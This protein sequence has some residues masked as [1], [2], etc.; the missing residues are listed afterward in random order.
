M[1]ESSEKN[2]EGQSADKVVD[3]SSA[4]EVGRRRRRK[5]IIAAVSVVCVIAL[6]VV[7]FWGS[8]SSRG[9]KDLF[10]PTYQ[11]GAD[12]DFAFETG[13][14]QVFA[15]VGDCLAVAS[16]GGLQI[17]DEDGTTIG[18]LV[19]SMSTPAI[20][21]S[22]SYCLAYD[23]GGNL[24][25][26]ALDDG[27]ITKMETSQPIIS[28]T[29]CK[30]GSFAVTTEQSGSKGLVTVYNSSHN[31]IYKYYSGS[32]YVLGAKLSADGRQL[33]ALCAESTGTVVH[34]YE[35][36]SET[37]K[38]TYSVADE[39]FFDLFWQGDGVLCIVSEL[40][41]VFFE[42]SGDFLS[43]YSFGE[44]YLSDYA[45]D[46]EG[47]AALV[48]SHYRSGG[49][50]TLITVDASGNQLA[51]Q[52]MQNDVLSLSM[53]SSRLLVLYSDELA[54][55]TY[56]L[57]KQAQSTDVL[58]VKHALFRSRGDVLLIYTYSADVFSFF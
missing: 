23:A 35:L 48:L 37:E 52:E 30:N 12:S 15:A 14:S 39:L 33:A 51:S 10:S 57:E 46:G 25:C 41:L 47:T 5:V 3:I 8:L 26:T 9:L 45:T 19:A 29:I 36:D 24:L 54:Q 43:E 6:F 42:D 17:I 31:P 34:I 49:A 1:D 20:S 4:P 16:T 28:A 44:L 50:G 58:G 18:R 7:I 11:E 2:T 22:G 21:S 55:Y 32:G 27:S 38:A 53:H 40:H 13:S 56:Q